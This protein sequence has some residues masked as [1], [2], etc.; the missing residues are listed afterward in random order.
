MK[1]NKRG[2]TKILL[3]LLF[4]LVVCFTIIGFLFYKY[5]YSG[6]STTKYGDRLEGMEN[7]KLSDSLESDIQSI[8][9]TTTS[10]NKVSVKTQGKI[11]YIDI[12]FKE[13]VK[14]D[15]AKS[16][17]VKALDKIGKENLT[18]YD[19]QFILTYSGTDENENFPV[20]GAKSANGLKVVW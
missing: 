13:S 5:F 3:V 6:T 11:I 16:E 10:V 1:K 7:Y 17:A 9:A 4:I 8:Y 15:T 19:V 14:L 18:F 20:F 12:D 2:D